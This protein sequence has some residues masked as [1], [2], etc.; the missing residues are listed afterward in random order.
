MYNISYNKTTY[1][2]LFTQIVTRL[3]IVGAL[4]FLRLI[5]F[6]WCSTWGLI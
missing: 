2:T 5:N 4:S 3:S 1:V 6:T